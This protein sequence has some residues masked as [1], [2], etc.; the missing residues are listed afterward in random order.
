MPADG[1]GRPPAE[2]IELIDPGLARERTELSWIRTA[3]SFAALGGV[4]LRTSAV[5]GALVLAISAIVWGI[6]RLARRSGP[7]GSSDR[8]HLLMLITIAVTVASLIAVAAALLDSAK[9]PL[10]PH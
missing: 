1:A 5:A 10:T 6:G 7:R 9:S 4:I 3:I 2:D 8:R